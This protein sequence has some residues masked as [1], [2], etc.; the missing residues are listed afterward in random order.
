MAFAQLRKKVY[1]IKKN[2]Y[3]HITPLT[4]ASILLA[5]TSCV[6]INLIWLL[7]HALIHDSGSARLDFV[8][9]F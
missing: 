4:L 8:W 3:L 2:P 6:I 7:H 9:V 1:S 5:N